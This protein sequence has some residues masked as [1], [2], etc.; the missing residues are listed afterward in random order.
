MT[1]PSAPPPE[2]PAAAGEFAPAL[3]GGL[4]VW[5]PV[6]LAPMAGVTNAPFRTLCRNYGAGLYVN[7]M[8]TA[9]AIVE[10]NPKT[11][12]LASFAPG[13]WPRSIQLYGTD[14]YS[15]A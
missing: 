4:K 12:K 9:R 1:D 14:G 5:P 6:V 11:L 7:Q 10:E 15:I 8:I 2:P 3:I 13:E